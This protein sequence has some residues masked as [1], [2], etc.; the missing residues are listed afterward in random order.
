MASTWATA[1]A[2]G[3]GSRNVAEVTSVPRR[4][5]LVSR[6]RAPNVTH[7]SVGPGRGIPRLDPQEMIRAEERPKAEP[8]RGPGGSQLLLIA[9]PF[10]RLREDSQLHRW[11]IA[12][13]TVR[14]CKRPVG[15][16]NPDRHA[17]RAY[18]CSEQSSRRT[19]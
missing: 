16:V 9:G 13:S 11:T 1:I 14:C 4:M 3:P 15:R 5:V 18:S 2:S 6:A 12:S 19:P 7:E 10:L 8:L 17:T